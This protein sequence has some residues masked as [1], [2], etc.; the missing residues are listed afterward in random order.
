MKVLLLSSEFPPKQ[1]GGIATCMSTL[2]PALVERG[3]E[4]HV[5]CCR[6]GQ[7]KEDYDYRGIHVHRR[8]MLRIRGAWR[9]L[10]SLGDLWFRAGLTAFVES[11]RLGVVFDVVEHPSWGA[12]GWVFSLLRRAPTVS[13]VYTTVGQIYGAHGSESRRSVRWARRF[14]RWAIQGADCVVTSSDLMAQKARAMGLF[15]GDVQVIPRPIDWQQWQ[16]IPSAS[17]TAPNALF[18]GRIEVRKAPEVLIE[19]ISILR[20]EI[21]SARAV[22]AGEHWQ[23]AKT[24]IPKLS[25]VK[26]QLAFDGCEFLGFTP[27]ELLK[28]YVGQARV[29][30]QPSEFE[31]F[32][33]VALEGMAAGRPAIITASSGAADLVQKLGTGAIIPPADP[34]AL[35]NALRPFLLDARHAGEVGERARRAVSV[36]LDPLKIAAETDKVY[37]EAFC[38]FHKRTQ[39]KTLAA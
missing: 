10:G 22:F 2:G 36:E 26:K 35:A 21:P 6:D 8:G 1:F 23:G 28:Q 12:D 39:A 5:L 24:V 16:D 34:Q 9:A 31:S 13:T 19:A 37:E 11:R 4:V 32:G 33:L 17:G 25:W 38:R 29:I 18:I 20:R 15:A 7:E 27:D 14:E 3:I 30:V